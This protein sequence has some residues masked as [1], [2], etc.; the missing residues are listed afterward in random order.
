M[1]WLGGLWVS[2]M[3]WGQLWIEGTVID[4]TGDPIPFVSV[5]NCRTHQGTYTDLQGRFRIEAVGTDTIELH[6]IGY[7]RLRLPADSLRSLIRL[8]AQP[9][10][11]MPVI[12]YPGENPAHDLIRR[13]HANAPRWDPL[14]HPH[15]FI[16]YN[17]LTLSL[18][19]SSPRSPLP[20]YLFL[21][22]TE[23]EK[24][25]F[26]PVRQTET[27]KSQRVV[28]NLPVQSVLSPTSFLPMSLYTDRLILLESEWVSPVGRDALRYYEYAIQDTILSGQDTLIRIQFFPRR[29]R[30]AWGL[31]GWLT[32]VLP[33]AAL[34]DFQ[35]ESR[36]VPSRGGIF[37][38]TFYRIWHRYDKL[39]D[40]L[41]F[42]TQLHSEVGMRLRTSQ[43]QLS[44]F[45]L[46]S[47]SFLNQVER[48]PKEERPLHPE[49]VLP[50][51][52][53]NP[54][55]IQARAE[56]LTPEEEY[57]YQVLDSVLSRVE[58]RKIRWLLDLPTL[59][60]GRVSMG[61]AN[62]ILRPLLL[63]H[64]GEGLRPQIGVETNDKISESFRVR[65]WVGYGT[66]PSAGAQ[67]T[68]W[69]YG[70]EIE[71]GRLVLARLFYRDD[72]R[73]RTLPRL[74]DE[75]PTFLPGEQRPYEVAVRGYAFRWEEMIRE[76]AGGLYLRASL[77]GHLLGY[78]QYAAIERHRFTER[79]R[80][81]STVLGLEYIYAQTLL[82]RGSTLWR[83]EYSLPRLH[84]QAGFLW[85]PGS[86]VVPFW[87]QGDLLHR[88][89]WGRWAI[90][91]L[92]LSGIY[93][94]ALPFLWMPQLR[95]LPDIYLGSPDMLA[96][97]PLKR[98]THRVLYAF[99][100]WSLPNTRFPSSRW[101]PVLTFHLQGAYADDFLY[102]E[103]G[104]SI[105]NW[106]PSALARL[107]AGLAATRIGVFVPIQDSFPRV[108]AYLRLSTE[109]F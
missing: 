83:A 32:I 78:M 97:H 43:G 2:G 46:R 11:V 87:I 74:L 81:L 38:V 82:R 91:R 106:V 88:W 27:L 100:E 6:C 21:W 35:G 107:L 58:V 37:Q 39:G 72:V 33:D 73:E 45:I 101:S 15:K 65:F 1:K 104:I 56:P 8:S 79:W 61:Y 98:G 93:S 75:R 20:P 3:L 23:T 67:G 44:E 47:R 60:T 19:D 36:G 80:G 24:R 94:Q 76:R 92:R 71:I 53:L 22:E 12:I 59:L 108:R 9:I 7:E 13:L 30:E 109:L 52:N 84:L 49:V 42:P 68:P 70:G 10:E 26:S 86:A 64:E 99:Y 57:S 105:Q 31:Q 40:T 69:R 41:W 63:Y 34:Y 90:V 95:T 55:P 16:S 102:P 54:S 62:L 4:S 17:K 89:K 5:R 103:A 25:Y 14:R 85:M 18:P 77:R 28:G 96:A 51:Q 66:H 50:S 48:L 29:G